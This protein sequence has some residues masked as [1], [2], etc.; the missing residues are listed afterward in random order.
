MT[1][2]S[3]MTATD[4]AVDHLFN[5][6]GLMSK[7][8]LTNY[9]CRISVL[10]MAYVSTA[11]AHAA[12]PSTH[13]SNVPSSKALAAPPMIITPGDMLEISVF[14]APEMTQQVRVEA[15]GRARLELLGDLPLAGLTAQ[16]ASSTIAQELRVRNFLL[17]PEVSVL[18]KEAANQGVS[19][20]GE[21]AHPGVYQILGPRTLLDVVSMAG[22]L[23]SFADGRVM[24]KRRR[25]NAEDITIRI[26]NDDVKSNLAN[27]PQVY[28][29]DLVLV[30]RA[31]VVYVLG[32]VNRPGGFVMQDG[33]T[34]TALQAL[35]QAGGTTSTASENSTVLLRR[36]VTGYMSS[37][38]YLRKVARGQ[39]KDIELQANDIVFVPNRRVKTFMRDTQGV[40]GALGT[41]SI[42]AV[43]H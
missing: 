4:A 13:A 26:R 6:G 34:I 22:G 28:P 20:S 23:T 43:A 11:L 18:I 40:V 37:K 33:G 32:D 30:P 2:T 19:I 5:Q 25:G 31:G 35:A 7:R 39:S 17:R 8:D 24:V 14:D 10:A 36:T 38:L 15:D 21:V 16:Q 41:A 12:I 27:D 3:A 1:I 29:G 42:Y 9:L